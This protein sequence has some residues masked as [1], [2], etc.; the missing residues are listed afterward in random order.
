MTLDQILDEVL[1]LSG[2]DT[3]SAYAAAT[4]D[5]EKRAVSVANQSIAYLKKWPWQ[6]LRKRHTITLTSATEYTLPSDI[7]AIIP[8]TMYSNDN[9]L[10]SDF[11]S[12]AQ[13]WSY[14][15]SSSGAT[16]ARYQV[17]WLEDE[18]HVHEPD[19]GDEI[20]FEY[21]STHPV[22]DTDGTTTKEKFV[23]DT[24]TFRL[25]DDLLIK[26]CLW[27][28]KK[29]AGIPD[30]EVDAA[31]ARQYEIKLRG[32]DGGAKTIYPSRGRGQVG[33]PYYNLWRP[34]PNTP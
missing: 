33:D 27:R 17:R 5:A 12:N 29:L 10:P 34:V 8:D 19:S 21:I 16:D 9:V 4:V 26:D 7:Q 24:D 15:K 32:Q 13:F 22:L 6:A 20:S 11:P 2:V 1:I 28:Y 23:A 18:L 30:W 3:Q 25:D 14:L 31:E